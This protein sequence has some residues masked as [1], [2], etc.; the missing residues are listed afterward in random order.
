MKLKNWFKKYG[1]E[2]FFGLAIA[3]A[4]YFILRGAGYFGWKMVI[5]NWDNCF[6]NCGVQ[7]CSS[8]NRDYKIKFRL[9]G[10]VNYFINS[11]INLWDNKN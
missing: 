6:G 5:Y 11:H 8:N 2:I 4:I 9:Y 1:A 3:L 7:Q 10:G